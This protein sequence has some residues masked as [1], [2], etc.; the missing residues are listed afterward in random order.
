MVYPRLF[1]DKSRQ[2]VWIKQ[3]KT[4]YLTLVDLCTVSTEH[5][6]L[7]IF[8]HTYISPIIVCKVLQERYN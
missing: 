6:S 5:I 4:R 3:T 2:I 1:T 8:G 7:Q